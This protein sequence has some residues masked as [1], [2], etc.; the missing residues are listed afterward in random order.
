MPI[1]HRSIT[2][3]QKG[4]LKVFPLNQAPD[5][6]GATAIYTYDP[7]VSPPGESTAKLSV[8][9]AEAARVAVSP[10]AWNPHCPVV[11]T[12][13]LGQD[14]S[15][16]MPPGFPAII[17][18]PQ[19]TRAL[20]LKMKPSQISWQEISDSGGIDLTKFT[21]TDARIPA[22]AFTLIEDGTTTGKITITVP[23]GTTK[24]FGLAGN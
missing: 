14:I 10:L 4:V 18:R 2:F 21:S 12:L 5:E 7:A 16:A 13:F 15:D 1:N 3:S 19:C 22:Y 17:R 6:A 11:G 9:G 8:G 20:T 23:D 24:T